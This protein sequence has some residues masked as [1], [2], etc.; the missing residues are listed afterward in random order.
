[1]E[2]GVVEYDANAYA[3]HQD[4]LR[5]RQ[6]TTTVYAEQYSLDSTALHTE[7]RGTHA[8]Y[9]KDSPHTD[10][11]LQGGEVCTERRTIAE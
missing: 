1:M 9:R 11:E 2:L 7:S 10:G 8:W 6:L 3:Y 4:A 5:E